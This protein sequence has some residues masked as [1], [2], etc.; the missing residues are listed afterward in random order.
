MLRLIE[1]VAVLHDAGENVSI[2]KEWTLRYS[3][4]IASHLAILCPFL[5]SAHECVYLEGKAPSFGILVVHTEKVDIFVFSNIL[6][7]SERLIK[8]GELWKVLANDSEDSWF[9]TADVSFDGDE[10]WPFIQ[11]FWRHDSISNYQT[12][13]HLNWLI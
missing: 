9:A 8:D 6:P 4:A 13:Y 7:L 5:N 10:P 3:Y 1:N 12:C 2:R 11:F